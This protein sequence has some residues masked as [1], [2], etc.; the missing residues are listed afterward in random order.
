M[1]AQQI[2]EEE[3]KKKKGIYALNAKKKVPSNQY[4]EQR[5]V[6]AKRV[7]GMGFSWG[8]GG[9]AKEGMNDPDEAQEREGCSCGA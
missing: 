5:V 9:A 8:G 3:E 6:S 2:K 1:R 7:V 4:T